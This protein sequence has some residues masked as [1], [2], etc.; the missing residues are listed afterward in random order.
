MY[1]NFRFRG[2]LQRRPSHSLAPSCP[3]SFAFHG[4]PGVPNLSDRGFHHGRPADRGLAHD[5][6]P[7]AQTLQTVKAIQKGEIGRSGQ[8]TQ[9]KI[10]RICSSTKLT[11]TQ[12]GAD[13]GIACTLLTQQTLEITVTHGE[14]TNITL[15]YLKNE[16]GSCLATVDIILTILK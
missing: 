1:V 15:K 9:K 13:T 5:V 6:L 2:I 11:H 12:M 10:R 7:L 3:T 14:G 8:G 4:S 16:T